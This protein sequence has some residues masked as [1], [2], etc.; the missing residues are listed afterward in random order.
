MLGLAVLALPAG[1]LLWRSSPQAADQP[2]AL[3]AP[4]RTAAWEEL[5]PKEWDPL[6]RLRALKP[7]GLREGDPREFALMKEMREMWDNAPT[8]SDLNGARLRLSGYVVPLEYSRAE[9]KE[10]LLVPYFGACV[11]SPPPPANQIV[12]VV[13]AAPTPLRMMHAVWVSGTLRT[14]RQNSP[15]GMSGYTMEGVAVAPYKPAPP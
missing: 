10:F 8:R 6:K 2:A 11:H 9:I 3:Q 4:F 5:V 12:H 13:L 15:W 1:L 7:D 14:G